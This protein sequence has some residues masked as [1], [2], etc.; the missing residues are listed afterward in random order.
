MPNLYD[1][2]QQR[3]PNSF[4]D[5]AAATAHPGVTQ[6]NTSAGNPML[7]R[8]LAQPSASP[9]MATGQTPG[10]TPW[11]PTSSSPGALTRSLA[12]TPGGVAFALNDIS[13]TVGPDGRVSYSGMNVG[14]GATINGQTTGAPPSGGGLA[15]AAGLGVR[16]FL[17]GATPRAQAPAENGFGVHGLV[18][19]TNAV[20]SGPSMAQAAGLGVHGLTSDAAP[21]SMA[22]SALGARMFMPSLAQAAGIVP[23][24]P[25]SAAGDSFARLAGGLAPMGMAQ[26]AGIQVPTLRHSGN[27]WQARNDLRDAQVSANSIMNNGGRFDQHG[28]G[29]V[30]PE[31]ARYASMLEADNAIKT[32]QPNLY[33]EAMRQ[34]GALQRE[35]I[36]QQGGMAREALSRFGHASDAALRE[37]G[38]NQRAQLKA[39][40]DVQVA[41]I[42]AAGKLGGQVPT[43]YRWGAGG[44]LEAIPGGPADPSVSNKGALNESQN[45]ALQFGSRMQASGNIMDQLAASGVDQ[46]GLLKRAADAIGMGT[47]AN[48]TQSPQQQQ[49]EQAQRDFVNSVL[50]R[51]SGA[52]ISDSEF[53]SARKQYFPQINDSP[54]VIE[55]KRKNRELAT[56]GMLAE[57]PNASQRV[58]QVIGAAQ[59]TQQPQGRSV[60]RSGVVNGRR[61]VQY[62][63]GS[64]EYAD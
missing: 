51:E 53:D 17:P 8:P 36:Q 54:E 28:R 56:R 61:V 62:S 35:G 25:T 58:G 31:R 26:A 7:S 48:W 18:Q 14:P 20:P 2:A 59:A 43:G 33:Q 30:S 39:G 22:E 49:V 11:Q 21:R 47:V 9:G 6:I 12:Q 24:Q 34:D 4:G 42:G 32:A 38:E 45:K 3:R 27:D 63:D 5:A 50:R 64:V 60:A 16:Q 46:P 1:E 52:A 13:K 57:V 19:P 10:G 23:G 40:S 41:H 29:V 55:Q 37:Q 44:T 15:Q